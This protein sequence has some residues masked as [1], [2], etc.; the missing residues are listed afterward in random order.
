MPICLLRQ[1]IANIELRLKEQRLYRQT[2]AEWQTRT[3]AQF[4]AATIPMTKKG[5]K[6]PLA[7]EA[8]KVSLNMED[9]K[10]KSDKDV[11][12]ET[13][14]EKGSQVAQNVPGSFERLVAGFGGLPGA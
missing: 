10:G 11:P 6:N 9:D 2:I 13:Y 4:I 7:D 1:K 5:Q 3:L 14:I 8:A 12:M